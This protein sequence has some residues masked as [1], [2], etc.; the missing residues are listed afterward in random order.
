MSVTH[1]TWLCTYTDSYEYGQG[2]AM[3]H[4]TVY[5]Y[6]L[7]RPL[8]FSEPRPGNWSWILQAAIG[9]RHIIYALHVEILYG[10]INQSPKQQ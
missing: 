9:F 1:P 3:D 6:I 2:P 5:L 7:V 4:E 8:E 10:N